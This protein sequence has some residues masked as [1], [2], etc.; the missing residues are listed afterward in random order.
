MACP[1]PAPL[2]L[3]APGAQLR[4]FHCL[5]VHP[6]SRSLFRKPS[7]RPVGSGRTVE[8]MEISPLRDCCIVTVSSIVLDNNT[9]NPNN[10]P[11]PVAGREGISSFN[12]AVAVLAL[13]LRCGGLARSLLLSGPQSPCL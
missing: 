5:F 12:L 10:L 9:N 2:S 11:F 1:L 6:A 8:P 7:P 13:H 4:G 3:P